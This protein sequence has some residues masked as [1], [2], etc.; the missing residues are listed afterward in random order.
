MRGSELVANFAFAW[1]ICNDAK[2]S[3]GRYGR[4][5]CDVLSA[6]LNWNVTEKVVV[7]VE[8]KVEMKALSSWRLP[9]CES[10]RRKE[11]PSGWQG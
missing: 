6:W 3:G 8:V 4:E 2:E 9:G 11:I 1:R 7:V 10:S 5:Q